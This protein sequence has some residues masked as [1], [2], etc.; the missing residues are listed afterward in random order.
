MTDQQIVR[1]SGADGVWQTRAQAEPGAG[2]TPDLAAVLAAG[3]TAPN[4]AIEATDPDEVPFVVELPAGIEGGTYLLG[5]FLKPGGNPT[6]YNNY[7]L[8][9]DAAGSLI[10]RG[11]SGEGSGQVWVY[12]DDTGNSGYGLLQGPVG[13]SGPRFVLRSSMGVQAVITPQGFG[14]FGAGE[15]AQQ[16]H[17]ADPSGGGTQDAEARTA[18]AAIL[19]ALEAYGL[20]AAT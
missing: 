7:V 13:T 11:I 20:L 10:L 2:A 1:E 8:A 12:D 19:N 9:V 3:S 6:T 17:I 4:V 18:I 15:A 16:A 14:L 5:G